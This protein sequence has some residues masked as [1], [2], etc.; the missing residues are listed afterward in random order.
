MGYQIFIDPL[1]QGFTPQELRGLF[2][3]FGTVR[4]VVLPYNVVGESLGCA[5][6]EMDTEAG[7]DM[8]CRHL[9]RRKLRD[10]VLTVIRVSTKNAPP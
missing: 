3:Q 4:R 1:P 7:A 6:V 10:V 8:A 2:E 5:Y 9:R